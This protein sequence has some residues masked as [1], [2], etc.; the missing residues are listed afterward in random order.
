LTASKN[1]QRKHFGALLGGVE[2]IPFPYAYRCG[3]GHTPETCGSE[4]LELLEQQMFKRLFAPEE[5]AAIIIEPIQGEGGFVPAPAF[6]LQELQAIC[7]RHGIMLIVDEVQS[8][9]G[10]TGKWWAYEH[11]GIEPDILCTAKGI[12]SGMPLSAF[13]AKESVMTWKKGSHGTTYGGNPVCIASALATMDLIEGGYMENAR[14]MGDYIFGRINDWPSRFK[15]VGDVRGKGLMIGIEIVRDQ[16]TKEKSVTL[17]DAVI[18]KAFRKGLL[19]LSAGENSIRVSPPLLIDQE[20]AD[21]AIQTLE[22][23]FREAEKAI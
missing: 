17:R 14:K 2:H 6:F 9:M 15:I 22:S 7:N 21:F 3:Y 5:I 8:G 20:Q 23:C 4:I 12:A 10:R 13:V 19:L 11:A 18:D 16:K 1:P